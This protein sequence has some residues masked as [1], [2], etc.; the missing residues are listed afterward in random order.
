MKREKFEKETELYK[1][2]KELKKKNKKNESIQTPLLVEDNIKSTLEKI[3]VSIVLISKNDINSILKQLL[4]QYNKYYIDKNIIEQLK[5]ENK[6]CK[7]ENQILLYEKQKL[8]AIIVDLNKD[9]NNQKNLFEESQK[10]MNELENDNSNYLNELND[11]KNQLKDSN[12]KSEE[13]TLL[14]N[15][16]ENYENNLNQELLTDIENFTNIQKNIN[17]LYSLF[18]NEKKSKVDSNLNK[19]KNQI[20]KIENLFNEL[21]NNKIENESENQNLMTVKNLYYSLFNSHIQLSKELYEEIKVK[22]TDLNKKGKN[23]DLLKRAFLLKLSDMFV[24]DSENKNDIKNAL[25][26]VNKTTYPEIIQLASSIIDN[27]NISG[28]NK[29]SIKKS[30][31]ID[32]IDIPKEKLNYKDR[33]VNEINKTEE[34][35][36]YSKSNDKYN[37]NDLL[38][39]KSQL[40]TKVNINTLGD[41]SFEIVDARIV[42]TPKNEPLIQDKIDQ[43]NKELKEL[44][45][46]LKRI[47]KLQQKSNKK[48]SK[49]KT[50]NKYE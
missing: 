25:L 15:K 11:I 1:K 2:N 26:N 9:L 35:K 12:I 4:S 10:K 18:I 29:N 3:G 39:L 40:K 45:A 31:I 50:K 36:Y 42:N 28:Y 27:M 16:L 14:S 5:K 21:N 47:Q 48:K 23:E 6:N 20:I 32:A 43:N 19:L 33:Y 24:K 37:Y 41:P 22:L 44:E 30:Q 8:N 7:Q 49:S 38:K 13:L 17:N 34:R 46:E